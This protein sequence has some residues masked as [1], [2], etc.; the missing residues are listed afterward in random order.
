VKN[1]QANKT[2][3]ADEFVN[4]LLSFPSELEIVT[5]AVHS[6]SHTIDSRHFA[7]EF[8]RR[9]KLADKG[10]VDTTKPASPAAGASQAG[11][12]SEVAKKNASSVPK[13]QEPKDELNNGSFKVVPNKKKG[14]KK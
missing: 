3:T 5:E 13:Q 2:S 6:V 1:K 8:I 14:G 12:W 7:E 10:L 4:N 11:G 9:R